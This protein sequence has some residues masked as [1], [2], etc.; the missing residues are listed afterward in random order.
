MLFYLFKILPVAQNFISAAYVHAAENM[1]MSE[2]E[3]I[4]YAGTHIAHS[5]RRMLLLYL[6]M[7]RY[8]EQQV[9]QFFAHRI[10]VA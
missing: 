4:D 3:L 7:K 5:E 6:R 8:L 1:R 2:N 10:G 9:A